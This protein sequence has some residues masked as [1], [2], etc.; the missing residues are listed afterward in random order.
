MRYCVKLFLLKNRRHILGVLTLECSYLILR[1]CWGYLLG[2]LCAKLNPFAQQISQYGHYITTINS[3][4]SSCSR[5]VLVEYASL[6][7]ANSFAS[8]EKWNGIARVF[9]KA[10]WSSVICCYN[11]KC[12]VINFQI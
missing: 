9:F 4:H 8:Y 6:I 7:S 1:R 2:S 12:L 11:D 5:Y 10:Y 3:I